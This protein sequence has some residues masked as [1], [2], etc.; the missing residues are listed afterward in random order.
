MTQDKAE[1][2]VIFASTIL[3]LLFV[4]LAL[5]VAS[6]AR[7]N[8]ASDAAASSA[9]YRTKCAVCHGPDGGGSAAGKSMNV[10]DLRSE[11]VQ[12]RPDAELTQIISDGKGGMPPFKSS[13]SEA[14][15]HDL[16]NY[17]RSLR[18]KK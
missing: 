16:V 9:T 10:P 5:F 2:H 4:G 7:A 8:P 3:L 13:L 12:K 15:I 11:A 18:L 6:T 17:V 1:H 14:Q